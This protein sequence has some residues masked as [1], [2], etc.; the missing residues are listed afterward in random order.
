MNAPK[1]FLTAAVAVPVTFTLSEPIGV[2]VN[3]ASFD[4]TAL[5]VLALRLPLKAFWAGRSGRRPW[6]Q[7]AGRLRPA[8]QHPGRSVG[9][10]AR[11]RLGCRRWRSQSRR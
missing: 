9:P 11:L 10:C 3:A 5:V 4:C 1:G 2:T 8:L 6:F 7:E